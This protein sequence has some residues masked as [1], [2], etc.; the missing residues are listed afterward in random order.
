[1]G[2]ACEL[3]HYT[4]QVSPFYPTHNIV[5]CPSCG[6]TFYTE[7]VAAETLYAQSYFKGGEYFDY[8]A[9]K[10][11]L[12]HNFRR[13]IKLLRQLK[14]S[15]RL[16]ELGSAYGF[17]LEL[18]QNYWSVE[19]IDVTSDGVEYTQRTFG[20]SA[21]LAEFLT[22][23]DESDR[24]DVICLWD[25]V[26][27]LSHPVRY[28]EKATR[29]LRSGGILAMTTGDIGSWPARLQKEHWRLIHPPT[30]LFYFSP[31]TLSRAVQ[32]AGLEV[33]NISHVGYS[34]SYRA[35]L[36]GLL[37]LKS[38]KLKWLYRMLTIGNR[39]DFPIY[40]NLY[41]IMLLVAKKP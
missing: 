27:H 29:W 7:D 20:I 15:G 5:K 10:D 4:G 18:A 40:L 16:L 37:L 17:F 31:N 1:M 23:P 24:Y 28:I 41:D 8:L 11:I 38:S 32:Q 30:H 35:M 9:D 3:C 21:R 36:H 26:E 2:S 13:R 33:V 25:T 12:Q 6:L 19:G 34:R 39:V 22:L 14:P